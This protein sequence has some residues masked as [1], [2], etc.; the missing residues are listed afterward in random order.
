M[1]PRHPIVTYS[2][3][4]RYFSLAWNRLDFFL[5]LATLVDFVFLFTDGELPL[6]PP[7]LRVVRLF[8]AVRLL[9]IFRAAKS[10][11]TMVRTIAVSLP[12]VGNVSA[13]A[14]LLLY[15]YAV[16]GMNLFFGAN[17]TPSTAPRPGDFYFHRGV[18][19][20]GHFVN[21]HAGFDT[22]ATALLT[23]GRCTT[24]ESYNGVMHELMDETWADNALRCCP[25]CGPI[26]DGVM[27][28]TP[29][30][31]P[32]RAADCVQGTRLVAW[33]QN[34][35]PIAEQSR[36][37]PDCS[38]TTDQLPTDCPTAARFCTGAHLVVRPLSRGVPLLRLLPGQERPTLA[39]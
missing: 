17:H 39:S 36:S 5:V 19:N 2:P 34:A 33:P 26:I 12:A 10:L 11:R 31:P 14:S 35:V 25:T 3:L 37:P 22:F 38:P 29:L 20:E 9:R 24:G 18:S 6:P 23:L 13:L 32:I 8:R 21:R 27:T 7:L 16:I 15:V 30:E 1:T 28:S 4:V